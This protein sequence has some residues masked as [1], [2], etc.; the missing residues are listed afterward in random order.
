MTR[1]SYIETEFPNDLSAIQKLRSENSVFAEICDD[2]ELMGRDLALFS[3]DES[4]PEQGV[5]L[6]IL[7]SIQALRQ[8]LAELLQRHVKSAAGE[9]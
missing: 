3:D 7:E 5:Y 1:Q 8:E 4:L 9:M 6:D 2:L